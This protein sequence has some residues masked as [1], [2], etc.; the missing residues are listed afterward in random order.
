MQLGHANDGRRALVGR[1]R[2]AIIIDIVE[3]N[4]WS[5]ECRAV[6][7]A[8]SVRLFR[9]G[10]SATFRSFDSEYSN[11]SKSSPATIAHFRV[12]YFD[13]YSVSCISSSTT[14]KRKQNQIDTRAGHPLFSRRTS[15]SE[16]L[17]EGIKCIKAVSTERSDIL[18]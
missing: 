18:S 16:G 10:R 12:K 3:S 13:V 14:F 6:F 9:S 7:V 11:S 5:F 15:S 2:R 8:L 4:R 17:V 1:V